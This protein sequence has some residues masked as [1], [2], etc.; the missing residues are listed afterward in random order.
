MTWKDIGRAI[1]YGVVLAVFIFWFLVML[2]GC[3]SPDP[4]PPIQ[5]YRR[6]YGFAFTT[7]QYSKSP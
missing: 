4:E 1:A 7:T 6:A 5:A 3:G 2:S